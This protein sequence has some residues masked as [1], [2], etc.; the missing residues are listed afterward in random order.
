MSSDYVELESDLGDIFVSDSCYIIEIVSVDDAAVLFAY[1]IEQVSN[2]E[3]IVVGLPLPARTIDS[4]FIS[5]RNY[6]DLSCNVQVFD[7][8][9]YSEFLFGFG[10]ILHPIAIDSIFV[11]EGAKCRVRSRVICLSG[12]IDSVSLIGSTDSDFEFV[13]DVKDTCS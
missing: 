6:V 3:H 7:S 10:P 12:Q 8:V 2:S 9:H 4:I 5:E 11:G 1:I 13:G